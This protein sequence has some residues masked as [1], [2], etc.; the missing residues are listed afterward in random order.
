VFSIFE[1][2]EIEGRS[3]G[4]KQL[5]LPLSKVRFSTAF[6]KSLSGSNIKHL[7]LAFY[8]SLK[9]HTAAQAYR[10]L[11][12]YLWRDNGCM[13]MDL[14]QFGVQ[15]IG[16][17]PNY[18]PTDLKRK[19]KPGIEELEQSGVIQSAT[20]E[21]RYKK[22]ER[23]GEWKVCF[24]RGD[25]FRNPQIA[26]KEKAAPADAEDQLIGLMVERGLTK[27]AAKRFIADATIPRQR[28]EIQIEHLDFKIDKGEELPNPGGFLRTAIEEDY[29]LPKGFM[30]KAERE[31]KAARIKAKKEEK[32]RKEREAKEAEE[33]RI[34]QEKQE[35]DEKWQRVA[36]YLD[37]ITEI[38]RE[39]L[40]DAAIAAE[41]EFNRQ[42]MRRYR[43]NPEAEGINEMIY[44]QGLVR[45]ILPMLAGREAA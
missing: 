32:A 7:D 36:L 23:R 31:D 6:F 42:Y 9:H 3:G 14:K 5:D 29:A 35:A 28:I 25:N 30:T 41:A 15:H 33:Q 40:I 21:Q 8:C 43:A 2:V 10:V 44:Q 26:Q 20:T 24:A 22:G 27:A 18:K 4:G 34:A 16:L 37:S 45:H 11:G 17:S 38:E 12:K 19:L 39:T 1:S 13:E